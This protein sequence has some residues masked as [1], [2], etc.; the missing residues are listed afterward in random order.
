MNLLLI[1]VQRD[2]SAARHAAL[3]T[4]CR[5]EIRQARNLGIPIIALTYDGKP[6]LLRVEK[7]V[8]SY[9]LL[10]RLSKSTDSGAEEVIDLCET[11]GIDASFFRICGVNICACVEATV[12]GILKAMP[13]TR[14]DFVHDACGCSVAKNKRDAFRFLFDNIDADKSRHATTSLVA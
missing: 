2:F 5:R 12:R 4:A 10:Y 3:I 9:P 8:R 1:D 6:M 14:F 7:A 13:E 11:R